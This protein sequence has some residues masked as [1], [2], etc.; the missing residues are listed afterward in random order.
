[1]FSH[2]WYQSMITKNIKIFSQN[3]QKNNFVIKTILKTQ[4]NFN[5]IFIQELSW[6][7][8][9]SIPSLSNENR[10]LLVEFPNH[11][12]WIM[13]SRNSIQG[14]EQPRVVTFINVQLHL[15]CFSLRKDVFNHRNISCVLFFNHELVYFLIN[16]YSDSSQSALKYLKNTE[17]NISNVL[18]MI[19]DLNIR[20]SI[21]DPEFSYHSHHSQGL[22][23]IA[24]SFHLEL[25]RPTEQ[26]STRYSNNQ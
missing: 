3:I 2:K 14:D 19:G 11:P 12:N 17:V 16:L 10:N 20:D 5:I 6:S 21:W 25:S 8:I 4:H 23:N 1:M 13:F 15:L 22:F 26:I 7:I 18:V 24:N 9:C